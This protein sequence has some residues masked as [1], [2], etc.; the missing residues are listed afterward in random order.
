MT[1]GSGTECHARDAVIPVSAGVDAWPSP[2]PLHPVRNGNNVRRRAATTAVRHSGMQSVSMTLVRERDCCLVKALMCCSRESG[3]YDC[4]D[5]GSVSTG[6]TQP[7]VEE[8]WLYF[9]P[10]HHLRTP[11]E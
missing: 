6:E 4:V 10:P 1:E 3:I 7:S 2:L 11:P 8:K 9:S 5:L